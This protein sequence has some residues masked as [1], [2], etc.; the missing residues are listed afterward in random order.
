[1][2]QKQEDKQSKQKEAIDWFIG[3]ARSAAGYRR[4]ILYENPNREKSSVTSGRLYF[5]EYDPKHKLKLPMYDRFPLVF[6]LEPKKGGF[7]GLN[8]HYLNPSDRSSLLGGLMRF[9]NNNKLDETTKLNIDYDTVMGVS[10]SAGLAR[11]CVKRYLYGYVRSP[12]IEIMSYEW[13]KV[14]ALPT[15]LFIKRI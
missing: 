15:E 4:N 11:D 8:V 14:I 13:D 1:M 3:K 10:S 12:F 6:P 7:L 9:G 5:F 2:A